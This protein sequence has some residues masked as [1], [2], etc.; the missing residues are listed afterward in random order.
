MKLKIYSSILLLFLPFL[1]QSQNEDVAKTRFVAGLAVPELIHL[2]A[3]VDLGNFNQIGGSA[4]FSL[5]LGR[6][7]A[8][9]ALRLPFWRGPQA[10]PLMH[11]GMRLLAR[12]RLRGLGGDVPAIDPR[13]AMMAS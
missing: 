13:V 6:L 12:E 7:F 1:L 11:A 10:A 9:L 2:G 4:G 8:G 3:N 5:S